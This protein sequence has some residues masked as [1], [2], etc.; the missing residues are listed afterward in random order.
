MRLDWPSNQ[1]REIW[2]IRSFIEHYRRLPG[3]RAF[4]II[5]KHERPDWILRDIATGGLVGV[6][7][8][9]VYLDDRSVPDLHGRTGKFS[10][11]D[12]PDTAAAYGCRIAE[13]VQEKARL[14]GGGYATEYPLLLSLYANDYVTLYM[15]DA[16]WESLVR[17]HES[18]FDNI[19]PFIEVVIWPLLNGGVLRITAGTAR[20]SS[21][22]NGA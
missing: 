14:A 9:S 20:V 7:L 10:I 1:E 18:T 11:S 19:A 8:T 12:D 17:Q 6:E 4:E 21:T 2:E 16:A 13:K 22:D 5:R 3:G 15:D